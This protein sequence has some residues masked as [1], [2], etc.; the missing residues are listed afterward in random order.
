MVTILTTVENKLCISQAWSSKCLNY[1]LSEFREDTTT[2]LIFIDLIVNTPLISSFFVATC[3]LLGF[4]G[5]ILVLFQ[6]PEK[7]NKDFLFL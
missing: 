3:P 5:N 6:T 2:I 1:S 7:E 4:T